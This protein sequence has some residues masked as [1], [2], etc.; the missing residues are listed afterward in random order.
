MKSGSASNSFLRNPSRKTSTNNIKQQGGRCVLIFFSFF[1]L[2]KK[3]S[4]PQ[5]VEQTEGSTLTEHMGAKWYWNQ[6]HLLFFFYLQRHDLHALHPQWSPSLR[7]S[8]YQTNTWRRKQ[9]HCI[10]NKTISQ[11]SST[12]GSAGISGN[13]NY[14][15][16]ARFSPSNTNNLTSLK[17]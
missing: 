6:S 14:S 7:T 8:L 13:N 4:F 12:K 11:F 15:M 17:C 2:V 1:F 10:D 16:T 3:R 9:L 5:K